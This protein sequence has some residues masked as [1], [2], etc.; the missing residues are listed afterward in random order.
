MY[1]YS[2]VILEEMLALKPS[3]HSLYDVIQRV[4]AYSYK[5]A[6][7]LGL[8]ECYCQM[9]EANHSNNCVLRCRKIF[10][11]FLKGN[12]PTWKEVIDAI[13]NVG[14]IAIADDIEK[15]L[16]GKSIIALYDQIHAW[17][18]YHFIS[19]ILDEEEIGGA[20]LEHGND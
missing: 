12:S 4:A 11:E 1:F 18:L 3:M 14:F 7:E 6:I 2:V 13:R 19:E 16:P 5:I 10:E 17:L 20:S 15:Q 9:L 8:K